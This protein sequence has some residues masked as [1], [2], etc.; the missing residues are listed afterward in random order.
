[1][2]VGWDDYDI[3]LI[4]SQYSPRRKAGITILVALIGLSCT[5]ASA[6][7]SVGVP[8]SSEKCGV[9]KVVGPL[10]TALFMIG[11]GIGSFIS[12]PFSETFGRNMVYMVTMIIFSIQI[13]AAGLA[14]D[15]QSHLIFRVLAGLFAATPLTFVGDTVAELWDP[16]QKTYGFIIYIIPVSNGTMI[17]QVIGSYIP[18]TIGVAMAG[19]DYADLWRVEVHHHDLIQQ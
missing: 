13:M 10:V 12:G 7:D 11:F 5:A 1:M 18:T 4:Q 3:H 19:M 15:I 8:Q 2:V 17:G 14:P 9:S 6:I 16:L